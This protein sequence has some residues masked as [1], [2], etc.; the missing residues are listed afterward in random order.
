[1]AGYSF[2]VFEEVGVGDISCF[3]GREGGRWGEEIGA[4]G[5]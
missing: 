3:G 1:M 5:S 4:S 2:R